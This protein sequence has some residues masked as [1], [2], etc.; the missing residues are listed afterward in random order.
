LAKIIFT[1][2]FSA[3]ANFSDEPLALFVADQ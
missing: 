1:E 2:K 3:S